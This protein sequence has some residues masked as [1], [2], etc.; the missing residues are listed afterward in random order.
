MKSSAKKD[1]AATK[2]A[3]ASM[4]PD[5]M[6]SGGLA[7]D[8]DG[9]IVEVRVV[10]WNYGKEDMDHV[11]AVRVKIDPA[12]DSDYDEQIVQHYSAGKLEDFAPSLDGKTPVDLEGDDI[13]EM[14]GYF[15]L[16]VGSREQ[17]NNGTNWAHFVAV[18]IDAGFD[19]E[20]I[21]ADVRCFEGIYAHFNRVPQKKRSGIITQPAEEGQPA[22]ERTVLVV[23]EL[24]EEPKSKGKKGSKATAAAKPKGRAAA[25]EEEEDDINTRVEEAIVE[26]LTEAEEALA[27]KKVASL[28]SKKFSGAEKAAV[29]KLV[30]DTDFLSESEAFVYDEDEETL[31]LAD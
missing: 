13:D 21:E 10:P 26:V 14:E 15:A 23:S 3:P 7:D 18:L 5:S 2:K 9:K 27:V 1:K 31:E 29:L 20:Q 24:L 4:R 22:R 19:I 6:A 11:L 8:F 25:A 30:T 12:E 17:L 16:P 28:V